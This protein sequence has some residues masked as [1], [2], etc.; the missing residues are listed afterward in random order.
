MVGSALVAGGWERVRGGSVC[1]G[2]E[3]WVS[4][5]LVAECVCECAC[6]CMRACAC[7]ACE[8]V[9]GSVGSPG[10]GYWWLEGCS[11]GGG[12]WRNNEKLR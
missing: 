4:S 7:D 12:G 9:A 5:A 10:D 2:A 8:V 1:G 11:S 3:V 6:V